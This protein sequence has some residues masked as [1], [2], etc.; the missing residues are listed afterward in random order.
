MN[1]GLPNSKHHELV[2]ELRRRFP[3]FEQLRGRFGT[4]MEEERIPWFFALLLSAA[5]KSEPGACCFVLDKS[6]GTTA[7]AAILL[8]LLKLQKEFPEL[9]KTY[10]QSAL[11]QGQHVRVKPS[12]HVYEYDGI[13]GEGLSKL[14]LLDGKDWRSFPVTDLLRLERTDRVCPKGKLNST[15]GTFKRSP[16][17][18]LLGIRTCGNNSLIRNTVLLF[19]AKAKFTRIVSAVTLMHEHGDE[20]GSVSNFLPWGTITQCVE[21][22]PKD[23]YPAIGE[24][25]IAVTRVPEDL[26]LASAK[27]KAATK[28]VLVDGARSIVRDLQSYDDITERQKVVILASPEETDALDILRDR[29]CPVWY[30]SPD[31]ILIGETCAEARVRRSFVGATIRAADTRQR[32]QVTVVKCN[33]SALQ[34]VADSL[35]QAAVMVDDGEEAHESEKILARLYGILLECS[36]CCFGVG[37]ETKTNLQVARNQIKQDGKWLD[38]GVVRKLEE[39]GS[40]LEAITASGVYGQEKIKELLSFTSDKQD[41]SWAVVTRLPRTAG[42]LRTELGSKGI[43]VPVLSVSEINPD[44]DFAGIIVPSWPNK[45][46]FTQLK[47]RAVTP[48]IRVLAYPFED[49]W[50]SHH[51]AREEAVERSNLMETETHSSVL[52]I[53]TRFL[54]S[55]NHR[56]EANPPSHEDE[57]E[58]P[59]L[60]VEGRVTRSRTMR[61]A[62]ATEGEHSREAQLIQF[63]GNCHALLTEWAELPLLNQLVGGMHTGE[64]KLTAVTASR[65]SPKDF[66]LFRDSGDKGFIRLI[67]EDILGEKE[68]GW[69][70]D[71]AEHWKS[72]LRLLGTSPADIQQCLANHGLNRTTTTI[73]GW[74]NNQHRIGP[75]DFNDIE[76]IAKATGDTEL[77]SMRGKIEEAIFQI[78]STHISAGTQLTQLLLDELDGRL[79]QIGR[80]PLLLDLGYGKAWCVQVEMVDPV[81]QR[82]PSNQIN[83]LLWGEDNAF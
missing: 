67:A 37:D 2:G 53:E 29:D 83:R 38:R 61:P 49:K 27:A 68:Y 63:F 20:S 41:G 57:P 79:N 47:A 34:T 9:A 32:A 82:Y 77:L 21:L 1:S 17:D 25:I 44:I 7:V 81:Q 45:Q 51:Q 8:G 62:I 6:P 22:G 48:D 70:R 16:L 30:M 43:N 60:R 15:L 58:L 66:V 65:L 13:L 76:F 69:I 40:R 52:G 46:R 12:N 74:L 73:R 18:K 31:E 54:T 23:A 14:K 78:R 5:M 75:G 39:A 26:A 56:L 55:L 59:I 28:V 36:E 11:H 42:N 72:P 80:Q 19:M 71:V 64:A 24:P 4:D 35:E 50:V 3:L 33:D 10:T